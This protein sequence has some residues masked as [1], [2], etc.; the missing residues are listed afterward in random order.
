MEPIG[1]GAFG[2]GSSGCC[3]NSNLLQ[4]DEVIQNGVAATSGDTP[5]ILPR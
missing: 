2:E 4:S 5:Q 3:Q 1:N